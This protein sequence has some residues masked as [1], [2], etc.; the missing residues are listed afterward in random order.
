MP[1]LDFANPL[2][3]SQ[4]IWM[5]VI[6][7]VLYAMLRSWALPEIAGILEMRE[8]R[9]G[10]GEQHTAVYHSE[11]IE[12]VLPDLEVQFAKAMP[13]TVYL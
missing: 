11:S 9:I 5:F 12:H 1:Q 13:Y 7:A 8:S 6:F 4:V 2:T 3:I 10:G